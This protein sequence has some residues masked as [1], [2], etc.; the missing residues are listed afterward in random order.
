M[1]RLIV[2]K[3]DVRTLDSFAVNTILL[4]SGFQ[5]TWNFEREGEETGDCFI[6]FKQNSF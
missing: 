4:F 3:F 5:L 6:F 2:V 1:F